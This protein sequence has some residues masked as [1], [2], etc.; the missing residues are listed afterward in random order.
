MPRLF[1]FSTVRLF[2][3]A[4]AACLV[5]QECVCEVT[6]CHVA[7][8]LVENVVSFQ[9][10]AIL[11]D[12]NGENAMQE[13]YALSSV[14]PEIPLLALAIPET[15]EQVIACADAGFLGY[16]PQHASIAELCRITD[17]AIRGECACHPRIAG[18]LLREIRG[19]RHWRSEST[20]REPLTHRECEILRLLSRGKSNKEIARELCLSPATVKNHVH[21]VLMKLHASGRTEAV[22]RLRDEPW[23]AQSA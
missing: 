16:V 10:D 8:R 7:S 20:Q 12:C 22:S 15:P 1:V 4:L 18:T 14:V 23:L 19:R 3:D 5:V 9:P 2:G 13:A 17:M 21:S 6:C 11:F